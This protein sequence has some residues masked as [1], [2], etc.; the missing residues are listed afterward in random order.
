MSSTWLDTHAAAAAG[1][2]MLPANSSAL[3]RVFS[4][5]VLRHMLLAL[6]AVGANLPAAVLCQLLPAPYLPLAFHLLSSSPLLDSATT[7]AYIQCIW[8]VPLLELLASRL[9]AAG[10][11][12]TLALVL[13]VLALPSCNAHNPPFVRR[14]HVRRCSL[15]FFRLLASQ[16]GAGGEFRG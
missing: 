13:S 7:H 11:T 1:T 6:R 3:P 2:V 10:D 12:A 8:E 15:R 14:A 9:E 4:P 5:W 16:L